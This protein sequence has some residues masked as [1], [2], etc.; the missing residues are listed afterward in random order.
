MTVQIKIVVKTVMIMMMMMKLMT[1]V[2]MVI[3]M[4]PTDVLWGSLERTP[5]DVCREASKGDNDNDDKAGKTKPM[6][7]IGVDDKDEN[8]ELW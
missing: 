7:K 3:M 4:I 5:K 1:K 8:D 2:V 6:M